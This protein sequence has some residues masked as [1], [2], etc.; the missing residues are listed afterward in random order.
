VVET[1]AD[2]CRWGM[3]YGV[4]QQVC[5]ESCRFPILTCRST[6]S[7]TSGRTQTPPT[8]ASS[9]PAAPLWVDARTMASSA[10]AMQFMNII[11][12]ISGR[13]GDR[14]GFKVCGMATH[15]GEF[16]GLTRAARSLPVGLCLVAWPFPCRLLQRSLAT[17]FDSGER[18]SVGFRTP[19][20]MSGHHSR[21][22]TRNGYA[23]VHVPSIAV[24]LPASRLCL[25]RCYWR[26]RHR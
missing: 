6:T 15:A 22:W 5:C 14:F 11:A 12:F 10:Y 16:H 25:G 18:G 7:N 4:F 17:T 26:S 9:D 2:K 24:V 3:N 8:S 19:L 13:M 1:P 21:H 20:R 23:I